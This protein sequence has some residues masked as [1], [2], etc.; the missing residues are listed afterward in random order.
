MTEVVPFNRA[1]FEPSDLGRLEQSIA[2]GHVSGNGPATTE[3]ERLLS[4]L[5]SGAPALL[6]PSC[7][8]ALEL[9][10]LLVG[11][12]PGDE[13]IVPAY[14]FVSSAAAFLLHGFRPVFCDVRDDTLCLDVDLAAELVGPRTRAICTVHYAGVGS[15][16]D[17]LERL[18]AAHDLVLIEDNAHGLSGTWGGRPLGTFG[19]MSALSFHETKNV[20]SG[21]GGA[22]VL[23]DRALVERA[24]ILQEKGT[25]RA[26]FFR[27]Q[28]DKYQWVDVGSSWIQSDLLAALLVGQLGRLDEIQAGRHRVWDAYDRAIR[29][30]AHANGIRPPH[31]PA[32]SAHTAHMYHLRLPD[33]QERTRFIDHLADHGVRAVFHYQ[34]LHLSEVGRRLGGRPGQCPVTEDASDTLVRLPL[35]LDLTES[36]VEHVI[37]SVLSFVPH[38]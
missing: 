22:L 36:Q 33:L 23:N 19:A 2:R 17:R 9:A 27:G 35:H 20:T 11:V 15:E 13:V 37:E 30:W 29:P 25:D 1:R 6:T 24:E 4:E 31:I 38:A 10:A 8:H 16:P 26:R 7:T 12:E 3:A 14:T 18:A 32:P 28:V 5:H 21:E 34:S